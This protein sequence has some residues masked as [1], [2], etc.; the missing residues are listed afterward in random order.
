[1]NRLV[2]IGDGID[3][4]HGLKIILYGLYQLALGKAS[5]GVFKLCY[6]RKENGTDN[7]LE[8]V[9]NISRNFVSMEKMRNVV[10]PKPQCKPLVHDI[11]EM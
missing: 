1:M 4:A 7:Y 11:I 2:L 6:Y 8:L 3:L 10:V 5:Y 9:K